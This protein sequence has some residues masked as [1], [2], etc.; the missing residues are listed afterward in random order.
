MDIPPN[1]SELRLVRATEPNP[2]RE[3]IG[4]LLAEG[5]TLI[6]SQI[7]VGAS[8]HGDGLAAV[9]AYHATLVKFGAVQ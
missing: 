1:V 7:D 9:V 2:Y 8:S 6:G 3:A 4:D 5:W